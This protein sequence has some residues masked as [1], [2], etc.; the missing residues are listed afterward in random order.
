[1]CQLLTGIA[2]HIRGLHLF[3]AAQIICQN[4]GAR[5]LLAIYIANALPGNICKAANIQRIPPGNHQP[6]LTAHAGYQ[7][8]IPLGK[9]FSD[10][11]A[12]VGSVSSIQQM[13]ARHMGFAPADGHDAAHGAD[14]IVL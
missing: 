5:A 3:P 10:K 13:A 8:H 7:L 12:V 2:I 14:I 11:T 1:M 4:S 9:V 6:L